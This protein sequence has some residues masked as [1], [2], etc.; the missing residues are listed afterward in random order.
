MEL[1]ELRKSRICPNCGGKLLMFMVGMDI[2]TIQCVSNDSVREE[3]SFDG[4][5]QWKVLYSPF[6]RKGETEQ[7]FKSRVS[8]FAADL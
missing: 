5:R 6:P 3:P 2:D 8:C 1:K 4:S 7:Q